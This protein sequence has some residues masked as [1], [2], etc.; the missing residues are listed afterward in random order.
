[1]TRQG[2]DNLEPDVVRVAA[3]L[4]ALAAED[5]ASADGALEA[6]LAAGTMPGTRRG[7]R[8]VEDEAP[9]TVRVRWWA[10]ARV[11][12]AAGI[13]VLAAVGAA[14]MAQRAEQAS[15]L[16]TRQAMAQREL[17]DLILVTAMLD[18]PSGTKVAELFAD[19]DALGTSIRRGWTESD[20]LLDEGAM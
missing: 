13:A 4:D 8:L 12:I 7:L 6:R 14:W 5:R 9:A 16:E 17:Q 15:V 18:E 1:M 10:S 3:A 19:A 2:Y 20:V 11:R